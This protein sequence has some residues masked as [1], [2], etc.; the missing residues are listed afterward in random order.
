MMVKSNPPRAAEIKSFKN[1]KREST[2]EIDKMAAV[3]NAKKTK[4]L[5]MSDGKKIIIMNF[6]F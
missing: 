5:D 3:N 1:S 2:N 4:T 6:T